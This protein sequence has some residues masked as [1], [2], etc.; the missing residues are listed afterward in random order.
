MIIF[1]NVGAVITV[2]M[3]RCIYDVKG[4]WALRYNITVAVIMLL[5][6]APYVY[7]QHRPIFITSA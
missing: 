6:E 1:L 5:R 4:F 3:V 2:A 7:V